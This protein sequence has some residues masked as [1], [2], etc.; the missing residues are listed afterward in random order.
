MSPASLTAG[1]SAANF[2]IAASPGPA[3]TA[4]LAPRGG[5]ALERV[6]VCQLAVQ[7]EPAGDAEVAQKGRVVAGHE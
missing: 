6:D 4:G 3:L 1:C 5:G 2:L 7:P